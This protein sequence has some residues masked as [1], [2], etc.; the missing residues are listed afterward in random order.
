VPTAR[1]AGRPAPH[2]GETI[3]EAAYTYAAGHPG[4]ETARR[5]GRSVIW[6]CPSCDSLVSDRGPCNGPADDEHGH[7]STCRRLAATIS[8]WQAQWEAGE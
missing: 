6:T 5:Y 1:R 8:A 3:A 4:T 2:A 7:A